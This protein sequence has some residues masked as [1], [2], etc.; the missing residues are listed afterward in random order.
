ML[1]IY[2]DSDFYW[3]FAEQT[4]FVQTYQ[5]KSVW[6]ILRIAPEMRD[7]LRKVAI[8]YYDKVVQTE[9][10]GVNTSA[11]GDA[12]ATLG[13][14]RFVNKKQYLLDSSDDIITLKNLFVHKLSDNR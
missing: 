11:S 6:V 9:E 4:K 8:N 5:D 1:S 10:Q 7:M 12:V 2:M 14:L 3:L 13:D